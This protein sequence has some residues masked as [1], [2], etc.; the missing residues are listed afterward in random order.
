M[1]QIPAENNERM[2]VRIGAKEK[3]LLLRAATLQQTNLTDFVV[4]NVLPIARK[5]IDE[6]EQLQL[7]RRDSLLV[8][9]LLDNPPMP[10][11]K[12]MAAAFDLPK[13]ES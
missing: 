13:E 2:S 5:I 6:N 8:L 7:T 3:A 11:A 9:D 1:P 10:N 12:L 4:R